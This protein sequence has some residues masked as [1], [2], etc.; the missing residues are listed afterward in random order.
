[1]PC[2]GEGLFVVCPARGE[3]LSLVPHLT[4]AAACENLGAMHRLLLTCCLRRAAG[5]PGA[6]ETALP[7]SLTAASML[8]PRSRRHL[9]PLPIAR[10]L[11]PPSRS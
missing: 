5:R 4:L 8:A 2:H 1:M 9:E 11:P 3:E 6:S 7:I 10:C